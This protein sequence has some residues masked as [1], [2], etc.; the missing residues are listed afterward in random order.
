MTGETGGRRAEG[1][2]TVTDE[3]M[4]GEPAAGPEMTLTGGIKPG[5]A[6]IKP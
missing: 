2:E 3:V 1:P 4:N 6:Q 5:T